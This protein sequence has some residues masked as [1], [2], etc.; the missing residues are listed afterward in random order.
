MAGLQAG[1]APSSM[2]WYTGRSLQSADTS[3][4][5]SRSGRPRCSA[6]CN[7][8]PSPVCH[9]P[10][11][12]QH[13]TAAAPSVRAAQAR[14]VRTVRY[15]WRAGGRRRRTARSARAGRAAPA[16]P[17]SRKMGGGASHGSWGQASPAHP[18]RPRWR[19]AASLCFLRPG[20]CARPAA[21]GRT[22]TGT[23]RVS[24]DVFF[25][26][27]PASRRGKHSSG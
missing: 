23:G 8:K 18:A 24:K 27:R 16:G 22:G 14:A 20:W 4:W 12:R 26:G 21:M 11:A 9:V 7:G 3:T 13:S 17:C 19:F 25:G 15:L 1:G 6:A 5:P 10:R 2:P